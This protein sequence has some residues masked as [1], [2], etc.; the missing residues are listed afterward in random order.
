MDW[1]AG[2]LSMAPGMFFFFRFYFFAAEAACATLE[3]TQ[4][5][6]ALHPAC[7]WHVL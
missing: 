4:V 1:G 3:G 2:A 6:S 7:S 5:C